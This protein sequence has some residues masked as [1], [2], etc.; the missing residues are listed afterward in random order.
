M[1]E[2]KNMRTDRYISPLS[3]RYASKEMQYIF[4]QDMKFRTW[5][6]LWIALAETEME[7]GLSKDG[8]P[9]IT[10][11][12]IDELKSHAEDIVQSTFI[13]LIKKYNDLKTNNLNSWLVHVVDNLVKNKNKVDENRKL[14]V[15]TINVDDLNDGETSYYEYA[16]RAKKIISNELSETEADFFNTYF[17]LR[18]SHER[19]AK[20][21]NIS[22]DASKA[23]K[24]R[25]K[26]R[27]IRILKE[28]D[29]I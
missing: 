8:K 6:K 29:I 11:E 17:I 27:I 18:E 5:R 28:N 24:C 21:Y 3:E 10:K 13:I 15:S 16:S 19:A 14:I 23:R 9:V 1:S 26:A 12:Q 7:L 25:I 22:I 20:K 2:R 4:S